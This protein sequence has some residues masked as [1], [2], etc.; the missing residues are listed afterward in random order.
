MSPFLLAL[1]VLVVIGEF[2]LFGPPGKRLLYFQTKK[3]KKQR[4]FKQYLKNVLKQNDIQFLKKY[5]EQSRILRFESKTRCGG[6]LVAFLK[7]QE[8]YK[9]NQTHTQSSNIIQ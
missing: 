1:T 3:E 7:L 5:F 8:T 4:P 6:V 2:P 9:T